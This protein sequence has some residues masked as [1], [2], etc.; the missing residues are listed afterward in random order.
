MLTVDATDDDDKVLER[1]FMLLHWA[2]LIFESIYFLRGLTIVIWWLLQE[3]IELDTSDTWF[4]LL[5][6]F[7]KRLSLESAKNYIE[8][9]E[10]E[11]GGGG[12]KGE[13]NVI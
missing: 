11:R 10:R 6:C 8:L 3:P 2:S 4:C 12:E 5:D 9:M 13:S 1:F 7:L